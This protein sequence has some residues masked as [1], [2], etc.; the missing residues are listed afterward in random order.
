MALNEMNN[1]CRGNVKLESFT[2]V[3]CPDMPRI[4]TIS[5]EKKSELIPSSESQ[6]NTLYTWPLSKIYLN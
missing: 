4:L 5:T 2:E 6:L 3:E 1:R